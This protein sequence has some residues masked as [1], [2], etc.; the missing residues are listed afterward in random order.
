MAN[1]YSISQPL[2]ETLMGS[3]AS[4]FQTIGDFAG[5]T[6]QWLKNFPQHM[7]NHSNVAF[8]VFTTAN[9]IFFNLIN[10]LATSLEKRV[11]SSP[12][13]LSTSNRIFNHCLIDECV[14]GGSVLSFNLILSNLMRFPLSTPVL[15]AITITAMIVR[16]FFHSKIE[17]KA[18]MPK[19]EVKFDENSPDI[20]PDLSPEEAKA[21][22]EETKVE[23]SDDEVEANIQKKVVF[24][25]RFFDEIQDDLN[26]HFNY[27]NFSDAQKAARTKF[28]DEL[29]QGSAAIEGSGDTCNAVIFSIISAFEHMLTLKIACK[30]VQNTQ[31]FCLANLPCRPLRTPLQEISWAKTADWKQWV[32]DMRAQ[33]VRNLRDAGTSTTVAYSAANYAAGQPEKDLIGLDIYELEK[34]KKNMIDLPLNKPIPEDLMGALYLFNDMN[35]NRYILATQGVQIKNPGEA[36]KECHKIWFGTTGSEAGVR[37]EQMLDFIQDQPVEEN[38]TED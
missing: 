19:Q 15:I 4:K 24:V 8:V 9:V 36:P 25:N 31:M 29:K 5:R 28:L 7:Q 2:V 22:P 13:E 37:S 3:S 16:T 35:G 26:R 27:V 30:E 34:V 17:K 10:S 21:S 12:Q 38:E 6:F 11:N 18:E 20:I 14:V 32:L 1:I 33:T 23:E